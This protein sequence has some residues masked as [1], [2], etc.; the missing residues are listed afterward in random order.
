MTDPYASLY[1][2]SKPSPFNVVILFANGS[3]GIHNF[4][5]FIDARDFYRNNISY[6]NRVQ[7]VTVLENGRE[8][9]TVWD[10]SWDDQ[11]KYAG[12]NN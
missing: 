8:M 9:R 12:L 11:S 2:S 10:A 7:R 1:R 6:S 5:A 4:K 3:W